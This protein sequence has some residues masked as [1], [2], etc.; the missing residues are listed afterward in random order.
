MGSVIFIIKMMLYIPIVIY[1][2]ALA[3]SQGTTADL[4]A[5]V[6][7]WFVAHPAI[8]FCG[9]YDKSSTWQSY[10]CGAVKCHAMVFTD[11][12]LETNLSGQKL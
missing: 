9:N 5:F 1:V 12:L 11:F 8:V 6:L 10:L 3:F 4:K 2:P 7:V